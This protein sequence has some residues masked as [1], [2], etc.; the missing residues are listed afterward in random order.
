MR[1]PHL[2]TVDRRACYATGVAFSQKKR[3]NFLEAMRST[4]RGRLVQRNFRMECAAH[5]KKYTFDQQLTCLSM[6]T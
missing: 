4:R 1:F 6:V 5:A 2:L 3:T